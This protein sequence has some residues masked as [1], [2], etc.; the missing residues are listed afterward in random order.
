MDKEVAFWLART[1]G[2]VLTSIEGIGV[3]L[4]GLWTAE[5]GPVSQGRP[6]RCLCSYTGVVPRS[7]QSGGP[8]K[9]PVVGSPHRRC[10]TRLKNAVLQAVQKVR[11]YGPVDLVQTS[12]ASTP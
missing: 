6:V 4:A 9:E 10:N 1:P 11:Q 3:T 8:D 2:A 7:K 5:L 12:G